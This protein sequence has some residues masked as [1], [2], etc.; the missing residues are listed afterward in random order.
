MSLRDK[1]PVLLCIDV[2]M[3]FQ[4]EAY[5]GGGRNNPQAEEVCGALITAWREAGLE[6][7]HV[8]HSS[9]DPA[10]KLHRDNDGF[11]FHPLAMPLKGE[12]I[13][14]K[15]VN[16]AFIGTDLK[17]LLDEK[18][19]TAL[20]IAGLT[21]DHCVSTTTRMAGNYG[22]ETYLLSDATATFDRGGLDGERLNSDLIHRTALASLHGEFATVLQ[23]SHLLA[24]L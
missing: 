14:T 11:Q 12:S 3:G 8:R 19:C 18:A 1:A 13:V 16:S 10:S 7:I 22:Y 2:Q 9:S 6:I 23:S 20:V 4:D 21:T 5:W 17:A 15:S 24:M